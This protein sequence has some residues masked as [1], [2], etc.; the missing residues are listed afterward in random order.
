[1]KVRILG[2]PA[3]IAAVAALLLEIRDRKHLQ[4]EQNGRSH[5]NRRD[6]GRRMYLNVRITPTGPPAAR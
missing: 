2:H 5:R 6:P 4:V 1:V 3:D